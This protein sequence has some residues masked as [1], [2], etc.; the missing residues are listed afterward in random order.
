M[1]NGSPIAQ[2]FTINASKA[3]NLTGTFITQV[4]LFFSSKS[5]TAGISV[6]LCETSNG[7]P[8]STKT[9]GKAK[10]LSS[11]VTISADSSSE[12]IF[13]F[14]HPVYINTGKQY[15]F[16]VLPEGSSPDYN[17][18]I[19]ELGQQDILSGQSI[20]KN[21]YAGTLFGSS[22]GSTW[23]A[24]QSQ[25]MKFNLYRAR[26]SNST[27]NAVFRN[28]KR[29]FIS[30]S[31]ITRA[32][33]TVDILIGDIAIAANT[34]NLSQFLT[35][36]TTYPYGVVE[37]LDEA[38]G[39]Y[40]LKNTNGKFDATN[41]PNL[42][43]FRVSNPSNT[44]L[45]T[46][47]N[48]IANATLASIDNPSYHAIIPKFLVTNPVGT[49][50]SYNYFGIAN[51]TNSFTKDTA[52]AVPT[53]EQL[54]EFR[55]QERV[56]MSYSNELTK[57]SFGNVGTSTFIIQLAT[58]NFLASP[59]LRLDTNM[60]N[61]IRNDIN[62]DITNE[63]TRYGNARSKYIG[64][65]VVLNQVAEDLQVYITGYRPVGSDIV[66][67]GKFLN[68]DSDTDIFDSK[69]WT[70]LSYTNGSDALYSSP[71]DTTDVKEFTFG[72]PST[73]AYT[74]SA[75]ADPVGV[76]GTISPGTLTYLNSNGA[77]VRGFNQF[78]IKID[79]ISSNPVLYPFMRDVRGIALQM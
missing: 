54:Y 44:A 37:Y 70:Q 34:N 29:D 18:W 47:Q 22:D 53:M 62:D 23:S 69:L 36:F 76:T 11:Q 24:F 64:K 65:V 31:N 73:A 15:A 21:P 79:L 45:Y 49:Y 6:Y 10:L 58:N 26:F 55:D 74:N 50:L 2:T 42:R 5:V 68:S 63:Q 9:L 32:N 66:V 52:P 39:V 19:A 4:G 40:Y 51:S 41:Y 33:T 17:L 27:G 60:F 14:N 75:Y 67:W 35:D 77:V 71:K 1:I 43:F 3:G 13:T 48:L 56:I 16:I 59:S 30:L 72:I 7:F 78:A 25:N 20:N 8:N 12:T 46:T 38:N 61:Y 57:G 28:K